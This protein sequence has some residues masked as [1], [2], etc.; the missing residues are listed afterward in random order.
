MLTT[1]ERQRKNYKKIKKEVEKRG[2]KNEILYFKITKW[3]HFS[4]IILSTINII[5]SIMSAT[6]HY[7]YNL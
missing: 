3:S 6:I 5:Q 1:N 4:V 7:V 2:G